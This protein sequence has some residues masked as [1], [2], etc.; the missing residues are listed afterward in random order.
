MIIYGIDHG[1][2]S[3][4]TWLYML[5]LTMQVY[6]V[7]LSNLGLTAVNTLSFYCAMNAL[8]RNWESIR[9]TFRITLFQSAS[10]R[11]DLISL[12]IHQ[13][14]IL[15]VTSNSPVCLSLSPQSRVRDVPQHR[16]GDTCK[17]EGSVLY[18]LQREAVS[19]GH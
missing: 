7:I 16:S 15:V 14:V 11:S 5:M 1:R 13:S 17:R 4:A 18:K 12:R 10:L 3:I 19:E 6:F 2:L 9:E 8:F